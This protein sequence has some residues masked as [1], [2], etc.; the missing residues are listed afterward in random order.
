MAMITRGGSAKK[1]EGEDRS[2]RASREGETFSAQPLKSAAVDQKQRK[3]GFAATGVL[4]AALAMGFFVFALGAR[5][6]RV[7]VVVTDREIPA[8]AV[9][10]RDMLRVERIAKDVRVRGIPSEGIGLLVGKV[11]TR[12][13]PADTFLAE[14]DLGERPQPPDGFVLAGFVVQADEA[15]GLSFRNGDRLQLINAAA[16]GGGVI[17]TASVWSV[18]ASDPSGRSN[19]RA[20]TLAIPDDAKVEVIR[21]QAQS[22]LRMV[23]ERGGPVWSPEQNVPPAVIPESSPVDSSVPAS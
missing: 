3:L 1:S 12:S 18:G 11:S 20:I 8:G 22:Q 9:V 14:E 16:E 13:I 2:V 19:G 5:G 15:P 7:A 6:E 17:T 10:T 23:L 4:L 21:V